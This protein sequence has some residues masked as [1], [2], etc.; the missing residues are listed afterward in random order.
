[1]RQSAVVAAGALEHENAQRPC[2][3]SGS[4]DGRVNAALIAMRVAAVAVVP[5][6]A[7]AAQEVML[8]LAAV[9]VVSD[10]G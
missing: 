5:I 9:V 8:T 2:G 7:T 6:A 4:C 10:G 1:M 3:G